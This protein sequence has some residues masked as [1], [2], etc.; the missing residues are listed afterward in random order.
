MVLQIS[1]SHQMKSFTSDQALASVLAKIFR[2]YV[3][4]TTMELLDLGSLNTSIRHSET[5]MS[6]P[7]LKPWPSDSQ[8]ALPN[9]YPAD[10]AF[11]SDLLQNLHFTQQSMQ[12]FLPVHMQHPL[13]LFYTRGLEI[14][15]SHVMVPLPYRFPFD[16]YIG[17]VI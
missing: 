4:V 14:V 5:D 1:S 3:G 17:M 15:V 13:T 2:P 12:A 10:F 7:G 16:F 9:S 8:V 6:Q 11:V